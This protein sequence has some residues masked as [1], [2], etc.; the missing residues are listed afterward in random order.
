MGVVRKKPEIQT[1][2]DLFGIPPTP[3]VDVP[4]GTAFVETVVS[5]PIQK[6]RDFSNHPYPVRNDHINR[7]VLLQNIL[8]VQILLPQV[9]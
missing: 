2:D 4:E 7:F 5:M 6:I 9:H 8:S 1:L 3:A